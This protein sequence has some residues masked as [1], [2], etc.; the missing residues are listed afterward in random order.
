MRRP[1][2]PGPAGRTGRASARPGARTTHAAHG[3][4]SAALR[5]ARGRSPS[6]RSARTP[7]PSARRLWP[8]SRWDER[9]TWRAARARGATSRRR[10]PGG[11]T[12][13]PRRTSGLR[14]ADRRPPRASAA[15][16]T[17]AGRG[18]ASRRGAGR[19]RRDPGRGRSRRPQTRRSSSGRP[20]TRGRRRAAPRARR[21]AAR[22]LPAA[23]CRRS[24]AS[25]DR[26]RSHARTRG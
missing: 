8:S 15:T 16:A 12:P 20:R 9:D 14:R 18:A 11:R 24:T 1:H 17:P 22:S 5:L 21:R 7:L 19:P 3:R 26:R 4:A 25:R 2:A 13:C 6:V 23:A 10:P